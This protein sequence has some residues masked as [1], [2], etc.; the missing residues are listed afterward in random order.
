MYSNYCTLSVL[1]MEGRKIQR[2]DRATL[3]VSLPRS[4]VKEVG[5]KQGDLVFCIPQ[6]DRSLNVM[7][8]TLA[9]C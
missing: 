9:E 2:V 3:A 8:S 6:K 4:W 5:I 7:L 1:G